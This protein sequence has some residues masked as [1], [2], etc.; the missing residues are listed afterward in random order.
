MLSILLLLASCGP[1]ETHPEARRREDG[2]PLYRDGTYSASYSHTGPEGWRPY[3]QLRV[4]AGMIDQACF[5]AVSSSHARLLDDERY[6]EQYRLDTGVDLASLHGSVTA[7]LLATQ[8]PLPA[9]G[10]GTVPWATAFEMLTRAAL[11]S[12][13]RGITVDAAGVEQVSSVGPYVAADAPDALG[14]RAELVLAYDRDS[15]VAGAYREYRIDSDGSE[16]Q[17]R[18]DVGL[19]ERFESAMGLT[20]DHVGAALIDQLIAAGSPRI[21]GV[22]GATLSTNRFIA[23]ASRIESQ[24]RAAELPRRLCR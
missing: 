20:S 19:Q 13:G 9:I 17:K 7:Q 23:L 4:R 16:R 5:G 11:R 1:P 3:L 15:V 22:S 10:A 12:A 24:R 2:S 18:D 8:R 21:D 14:W 6:I